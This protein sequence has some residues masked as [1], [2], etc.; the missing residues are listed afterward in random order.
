MYKGGEGMWAWLFHRIAGVAIA[1]FLF[2]HVFDIYLI[3]WGRDVFNKIIALYRHP[4]FELGAIA[5][6]A[7]VLFHAL[8]GIRLII[9]NLFPQATAVQK[10]MFYVELFIVAVVFIP[11]AYVMLSRLIF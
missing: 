10:H 6:I 3:G 2:L 11:V 1:L 7:A 9:V 8:N 5:L 4:L